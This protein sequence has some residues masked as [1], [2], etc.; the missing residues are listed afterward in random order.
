[1]FDKLGVAGVA[2]FLVLLAGVGVIAWVDLRIAAGV[3][4]V[5]AGL[6]LVVYGLVTNLLSALGMGGM[7]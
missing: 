2:G 5:I 6:G 3:A 1:M 7:V 4:F